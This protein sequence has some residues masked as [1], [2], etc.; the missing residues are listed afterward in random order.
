MSPAHGIP[1]RA[2][3]AVR[4]FNAEMEETCRNN[5]ISPPALAIS[6]SAGY[7]GTDDRNREP[8]RNSPAAMSSGTFSG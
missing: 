4:A 1:A 5:L 2:P 3:D 8:T 7:F 6:A